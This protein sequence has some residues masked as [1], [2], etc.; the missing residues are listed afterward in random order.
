ME[1]W[2]FFKVCLWVCKT[3]DRS[4]SPP[5]L[6]MA[7]LARPTLAGVIRKFANAIARKAAEARGETF[8]P[9]PY[10]E[11]AVDAVVV[12]AVP[13][14]APVVAPEPASLAVAAMDARRPRPSF[15]LVFCSNC[16]FR[17]SRRRRGRRSR[18]SRA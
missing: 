4:P 12:T 17:R 14:V 7:L 6:D 10:D 13:P 15:A 18:R 8:V 3:I 11:T 9:T 2:C 5:Q 1:L 16:S